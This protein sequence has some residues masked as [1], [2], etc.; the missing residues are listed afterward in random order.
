LVYKQTSYHVQ[1]QLK[2][3]MTRQKDILMV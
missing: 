2:A 3:D 1:D